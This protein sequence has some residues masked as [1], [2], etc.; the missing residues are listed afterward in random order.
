M[1]C[2]KCGSDNPNGSVFCQNCGAKLEGQAPPVGFEGTGVAKKQKNNLPIIIGAAGGGVVLLVIILVLVFSRGGGKDSKQ[3]E[4]GIVASDTE[5]GDENV[6]DGD[7]AEQAEG[8]SP[9]D[10]YQALSEASIDTEYEFTL[11][12]DAVNFMNSHPDFF[13]GSESNLEAMTEEVDTSVDFPQISKKQTQYSDRLVCVS[14]FVLDCEEVEI[15]EKNLTITAIQFM[16]EV[17]SYNYYV[18]YIGALD[19][20][21]EDTYVTCYVLPFGTVTFENMGATYTEAVTG[22]VC[23]C[24]AE[25]LTADS[26]D[27]YSEGDGFAVGD[28]SYEDDYNG[29]TA[30][31][32]SDPVEAALG[33]YLGIVDRASSQFEP[34]DFAT[35]TYYYALVQ[36]EPDDPVPTLL[37]EQEWDTGVYYVRMF[38]YDPV[39]GIVIAPVDELMEGTASAGGF[40][41]SLGME[42]DGYGIWSFNGYSNTGDASI[43]RVT[44]VDRELD[45]EE[46]WSGMLFDDI[47]E[48][49]GF[50]EIE[51]FDASDLSYL[52]NYGS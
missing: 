25:N 39:S 22:A 21:V 50:F 35:G 6:G 8:P 30:T 34:C 38:Q 11:T 41:G 14:G 24:V 44:L 3:E 43:Y 5:V 19:D 10:I 49:M 42:E 20:V 1:F 9:A 48:G 46:Q 45:M 16:N 40:R 52:V 37:L 7:V 2:Q 33:E 12:D 4:E 51:W 31:S 28:D 13:P 29:G 47:P 36:L 32:S 15:E 18:Y 26:G 17:T 27:G 23:Y